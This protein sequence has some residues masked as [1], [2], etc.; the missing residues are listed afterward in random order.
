MSLDDVKVVDAVGIE[1]AT[2][3]VMLSIIDYWDWQNERQ[4]LLALQDKLN[5]YFNFV[6]S[7]QLYTEYPDAKGR[8]LCIDIIGKFP[9]PDTGLVFLEKAS[10]VALEL[11]IKVTHR[12]P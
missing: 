3:V 2:G 6:E 5:A 1:K 8:S 4:H 7:G 12:L 9:I 11:N 10:L